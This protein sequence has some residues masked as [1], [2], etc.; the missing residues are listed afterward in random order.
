[1]HELNVSPAHQWYAFQSR[2]SYRLGLYGHDSSA[3]LAVRTSAAHPLTC[4]MICSLFCIPGTSDIAVLEWRLLQY[5]V[6][7]YFLSRVPHGRWICLEA[8]QNFLWRTLGLGVSHHFRVAAVMRCE[9][10]AY[11]YTK[12]RR[13]FWYAPTIHRCLS[14]Q[15]FCSCKGKSFFLICMHL[16]SSWWGTI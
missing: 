8:G 10:G 5:Y 2:C 9:I 13:K 6:I 15:Y 4:H 11:I 16:P 12:K 7:P 1:M 14:Y 3:C